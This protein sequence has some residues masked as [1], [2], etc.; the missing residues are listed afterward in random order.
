M[1][2]N[3]P[4]DRISV[5]SNELGVAEVSID[6]H[7]DGDDRWL[8]IHG[9]DENGNE[10]ALATVRTGKVFWSYNDGATGEWADGLELAMTVGEETFSFPQPDRRAHPIAEPLMTGPQALSRIPIVQAEIQRESGL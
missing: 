9:F 2:C 7:V 8:S 10:I 4:G 3:P 6:R 1:A 5:G